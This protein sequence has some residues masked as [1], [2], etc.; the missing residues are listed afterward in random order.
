MLDVETH[1]WAC[2]F[3]ALRR[4][5][6]DYWKVSASMYHVCSHHIMFMFPNSAASLATELLCRFWDSNPESSRRADSDLKLEAISPAPCYCFLKV[7]H[8][9]VF[10]SVCVC[11]H[12]T[13]GV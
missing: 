3:S 12:L 6:Q 8:C 7:Y 2:N 5:R 9:D 13:A 10:K 11:V 1:A 4:L